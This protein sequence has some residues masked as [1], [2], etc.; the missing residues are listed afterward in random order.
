MKIY[1]DICFFFANNF[2]AIFSIG[3]P[4]NLLSF[5]AT[6]LPSAFAFIPRNFYS[7]FC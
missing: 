4:M 5:T 7:I 2:S 3:G 6:P 1:F